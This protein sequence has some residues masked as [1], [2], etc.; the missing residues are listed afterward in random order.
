M[1]RFGR[2][3]LLIVAIGGFVSAHALVQTGN[4]T[5]LPVPTVTVPTLP[6]DDADAARALPADADRDGAD[7]PRAADLDGAAAGA[8]ATG[9]ATS[10]DDTA[11]AALRAAS[12]PAGD[13]DDH[14][15]SARRR[16]DPGVEERPLHPRRAGSRRIAAD[17]RPACRFRHG[18]RVLAR[19]RPLHGRPGR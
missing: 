19:P 18:R 7:P 17:L 12:R 11:R 6:A 3:G 4:A 10:C 8:P 2:L 1:I 5:V 14:G 13:H 16:R 9:D 15:A